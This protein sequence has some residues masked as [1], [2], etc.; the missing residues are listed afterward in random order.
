MRIPTTVTLSLLGVLVWGPASA[1]DPT[2][3][4]ATTTAP[5]ATAKPVHAIDDDVVVC[6]TM[7]VTGSRLGAK[8]RCMTKADWRYEHS[9]AVD[10]FRTSH[11]LDQ[12][13]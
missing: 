5:A 4:T 7:L 13:Y 6:K 8:K 2:P 1:A 12:K 9:S 3:A 10:F 11:P